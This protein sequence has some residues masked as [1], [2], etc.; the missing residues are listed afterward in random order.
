MG[1]STGKA[2]AEALK[3]LAVVTGASSGIGAE[4]ARQ[5]AARGHNLLLI[6]RRL[7]R[8]EE[9]AAALGASHGVKAEALAADLS[10]LADLERVAARLRSEPVELLV[11][12]AGFGVV[13]RFFEAD[14]ETQEQMV[15]VHVG[16]TLRLTH[17]VLPGMVARNRGAVVNVSSL[18]AYL[19]MPGNAI[20]A[21]TKTFLHSFTRSLELDLA[22]RSS[23][24]R[25]QVLCPGLT[26]TEFHA[27]M[28]EE[29]ARVPR[30]VWM[31]AAEVVAASLRGLDRNHVVVVPGLRSKLVVALLTLI[32]TWAMRRVGAQLARRRGR[33]LARGPGE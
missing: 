4:F 22:S 17:A 7:D 18:A 23:R 13:E 25:V 6:A 3:G 20:Y 24:V 27:G 32:P 19:A 33:R 11:N 16:A 29:V 9:L 21:A 8:L 1:R 2:G 26:R 10:S 31:P 14:L 28:Q 15:H 12:N 30:W 5:L